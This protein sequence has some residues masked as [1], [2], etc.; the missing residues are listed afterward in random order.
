MLTGEQI[1]AARALIRWEQTNLAEASGISVPTIRRL[2]AMHGE[3]SANVTT[4]RNIQSAFEVAGLEFIEG[5]GG[6][7][8]VRLKAG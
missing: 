1:R 4:V 7:P 3:V 5:S 8:G 6:G 2:E